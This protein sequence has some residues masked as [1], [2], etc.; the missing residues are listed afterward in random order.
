LSTDDVVLGGWSGDGA[1]V[2]EPDLFASGVLGVVELSAF[3]GVD[4][5]FPERLVRG[6]LCRASAIS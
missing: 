2:S 5:V 4:V 3:F 1:V 6:W